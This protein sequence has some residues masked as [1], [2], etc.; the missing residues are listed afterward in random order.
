[1]LTKW[2]GETY[3]FLHKLW[4]ED[5]LNISVMPI[6]V[7]N[8]E[9]P[10]AL[11]HRPLWANDVFGYNDIDGRLLEYLNRL[12]NNNYVSG[13]VF[14]TFV[15]Q[16]PKII[17]Y[18][19]DRFK[20]VGGKVL[21]VK[22]K[23]LRDPLLNGY[24]VVVNCT[25]LGAREMVPDRRVFPIRGQ[26]FKVAAPWINVTVIDDNSGHYI[27]PN[28]ETCVL[29][30]THQ[31]EDFNTKLDEK[32]TDFILNGC[33]TIIPSLTDAKIVKA[34]VGLR[35]GRDEVRI[36]LEECDGKLYI[37]NYGHGGSGLTLFWGCASEVLDNLSQWW[38]KLRSPITKSKL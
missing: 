32:D 37:H 5:G 8:R 1:M 38:D 28:A 24:Q 33:R 30:G 31:E 19:L 18:L 20:A 23:S 7:L 12:Y 14:T 13:H 3:H 4:L 2:G 10:P 11:A 27:I 29:G 25:G 9:V 22:I 17:S 26:I 35:P 16:P 34:W 21:Q 36:E 6:Y 15:V